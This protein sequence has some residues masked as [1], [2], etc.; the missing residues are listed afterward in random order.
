MLTWGSFRPLASV[1]PPGLVRPLDVACPCA[2]L[3]RGVGGGAS[4]V[5]EEGNG[6]PSVGQSPKGNKSWFYR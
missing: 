3:L 5:G 4:V 1:G 6:G 2:L